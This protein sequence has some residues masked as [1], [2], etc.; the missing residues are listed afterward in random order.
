M[1]NTTRAASIHF[2]LSTPDEIADDPEL[3]PLQILLAAA[4]ISRRALLAAQ[5]ELIDRSFVDD[6]ERTP[7]QCFAASI[8]AALDLLAEAAENYCAH[9]D[10]LA[11]RARPRRRDDLDF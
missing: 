1:T 3:A 4:E 7:R 8:L 5:P 9:L 2:L 6:P 11:A 10:H